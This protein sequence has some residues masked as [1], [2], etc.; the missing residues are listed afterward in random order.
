[1]H[2]LEQLVFNVA[3]VRASFFLIVNVFD[4]VHFFGSYDKAFGHSISDSVLRVS[5]IGSRTWH[6]GIRVVHFQISYFTAWVSL[7][8]SSFSVYLGGISIS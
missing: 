4:A 2:Y 1:M 7:K 5:D 8:C 6:Y 3:G